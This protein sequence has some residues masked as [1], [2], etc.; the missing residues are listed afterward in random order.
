[1]LI[2]AADDEPLLLEDLKD[3]ILQAE[4]SARVE[5]FSWASP[6]LEQMKAEKTKPDAAFLDVEMPGM[7]GME[8]AREIKRI[9]PGTRLVFVTGFRRY[10]VEAFAIRADGYVMKPVTVEK[11]QNELVH[12]RPFLQQKPPKRIRAHCFG[13]FE[14]FIDGDPMHFQY[15]KSR[16]LMAYLVSRNG[17]LSRNGEIMAVLW[18][19]ESVEERKKEY[20]KKLRG[21][22]RAQL[23]SCGLGE[24]MVQQRGLLGIDPEEIEC[25]IIM[26]G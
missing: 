12:I 16:E 10:A 6:L 21:D 15:S 25:E 24:V 23:E 4:P 26:T 5:S 18:E 22:I 9:S 17:A 3:S 19:D 14:I 20:F 8:L 13:N 11:I 1:M 7:S 2:Y